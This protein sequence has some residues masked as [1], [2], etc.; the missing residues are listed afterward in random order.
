MKSYPRAKLLTCA[1]LRNLEKKYGREAVA[2][3]GFRPGDI[4][5]L[6]GPRTMHGPCL[7]VRQMNSLPWIGE[8]RENL[9]LQNV[10]DETL[11]LETSIHSRRA[12]KAL[13]SQAW[14]MYA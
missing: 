10:I 7:E 6:L 2:R 8:V 12:E 1:A 9:E 13:K 14:E 4:A 11:G 5:I 3:M